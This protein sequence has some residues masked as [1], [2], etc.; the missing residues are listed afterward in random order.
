M[1]DSVGGP[2]L[3]GLIMVYF[4]LI[5]IALTVWHALGTMAQAI[6]RFGRW[7]ALSCRNWE[8]AGTQRSRSNE[9]LREFDVKLEH[10]S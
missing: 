2:L 9:R 6:L 7:A 8:R 3:V 10:L 4:G 5:L 1:T